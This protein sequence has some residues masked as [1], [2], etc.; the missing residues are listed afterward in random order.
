MTSYSIY[1]IQCEGPGRPIKIGYAEDPDKRL[2]NLQA[3]CPYRLV[4]LE[5]VELEDARE[6]EHKLHQRFRARV[7][8]GEWFEETPELLDLVR[9]TKEYKFD[10]LRMCVD[11]TAKKPKPPRELD[12]DGYTE[13]EM[14]AKE[15]ADANRR[16]RYARRMERTRVP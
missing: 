13:S 1:F 12:L 3:G 16:R 11:P 7:L 6:L 9:R 4:L 10:V 8:R 15:I 2:A 14:T 5:D